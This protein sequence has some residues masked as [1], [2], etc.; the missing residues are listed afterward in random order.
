MG[1]DCLV[2]LQVWM[3]KYPGRVKRSPHVG[4]YSVCVSV[5]VCRRQVTSPPAPPKH[6]SA[7][8]GLNYWS[9]PEDKTKEML[10]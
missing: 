10:C 9:L 7:I 1:R 6:D 4:S 8:G 3:M 2:F 5:Y